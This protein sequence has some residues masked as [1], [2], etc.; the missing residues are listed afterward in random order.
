MNVRIC[1]QIDNALV[2]VY[3]P[4]LFAPTE[5]RWFVRAK[6]VRAPWIGKE[7]LGIIAGQDIV[8]GTIICLCGGRLVSDLSAI[9]SKYS[10]ATIVNRNIFIVPSSYCSPSIDW[11]MNHN[12]D[13]NVSVI[14]GLVMKANRNIKKGKE[15][16]LNY[17]TLI[18]SVPNFKMNCVCNA[19]KCR[20]LITG[21]D[22]KK[23]S[24]ASK[25][26]EEWPS[27]IQKK[28]SIKNDD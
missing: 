1:K 8:K 19:K 3:A 22:W 13:N 20:K 14:A 28:I 26:Y 2:D 17:S 21:A 16:T 18:A 7:A 25:Y 6:K 23:P 9:P 15:L 12:C 5:S 27:F 24:L 4:G 10:Y 11:F